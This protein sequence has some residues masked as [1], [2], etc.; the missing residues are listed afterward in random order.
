QAQ[1]CGEER[2]RG[3]ALA[4]ICAGRRRIAETCHGGGRADGAGNGS[5]CRKARTPHPCEEIVA[6]ILLAAEEMRAAADVEQN[7]VGRIDGDERRVAL[8]ALAYGIA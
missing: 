5:A 4:V 8:A 6:K 3:L 2:R 1:R 7:A